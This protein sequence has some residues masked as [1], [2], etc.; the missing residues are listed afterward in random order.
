MITA[1]KSKSKQ[2]LITTVIA[3]FWLTAKVLSWKL[4]LSNRNFPV[5]AAFDILEAVPN[6]FHLGLLLISVVCLLWCFIKPV[7]SKVL[8][9]IIIVEI[10][11]CLL[12][13]N[14]WQPWEYQY[15]WMFFVIWYNRKDEN[16][17]LQLLLVIFIATYFYSGLQKINPHFITIIWKQVVLEKLLHLSSNIVQN[18]NILR[19]GYIIPL[20]E[21]SL[22]F[23]VMFKQSRKLALKIIIGMHSLLL[24]I[25]GPFGANFNCV[26]WPWNLAMICFAVIVYNEKIDIYEFK[27]IKLNLNILTLIAWLIMPAFS[28]FGY[29]DHY[30]SL[31]LYAA[32]NEVC[33]I[34]INNPPS[35]FELAKYYRK[36]KEG[37]TSN[38]KTIAMQTWAMDEIGTPPCPQKRVYKKIKQ[39]W[40]KK[41]PNLE[42]KFIMLDRNTRKRIV[43]EL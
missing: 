36:R 5:V 10:A 28:F 43:V 12:D 4:W 41:Y 25:V 27:N 22:G 18:A 14:R 40:Q 24:I 3:L 8:L 11:S 26:I 21:I 7:Q 15:L 42:T 31:S 17:A 37:D 19:V 2:H 9:L 6:Y 29:W 35:N 1:I 23:G 34:K 33:Y 32:R 30:F 16:R 38:T 39:Q 20:I 13:Q